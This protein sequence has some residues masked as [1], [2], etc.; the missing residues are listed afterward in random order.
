MNHSI[1]E[2]LYAAGVVLAGAGLTVLRTYFQ[3]VKI[4]QKLQTVLDLARQVVQAAEETGGSGADKYKVAETALVSLA[5]R[6]G[7]SLKPEEVHSFV[8]AAVAEMHEVQKLMEQ[9]TPEA[10]AAA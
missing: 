9:Q 3:T 8:Q 1:I 2:A 5:K 6:V 4:P 7:V 10:P